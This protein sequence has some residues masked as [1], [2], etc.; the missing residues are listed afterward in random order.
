MAKIKQKFDFDNLKPVK[1][2]EPEKVN[3]TVIKDAP[4]TTQQ[5]I[6]DFWKVCDEDHKKWKT[7][8]KDAILADY[9]QLK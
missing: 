9:S 8:E 2:K 3:E 1:Q 4:K 5:I 6:D 7:I